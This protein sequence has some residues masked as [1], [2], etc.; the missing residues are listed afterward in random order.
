MSMYDLLGYNMSDYDTTTQDPRAQGG[1]EQGNQQ[2]S[3][4]EKLLEE[5]R[6]GREGA[7]AVG[8]TPG[9]AADMMGYAQAPDM[10]QYASLGGLQGL[11]QQAVP[12]Q[13]FQPTQGRRDPYLQSLLGV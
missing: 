5:S 11:L 2:M 4:W 8:D 13:Q 3:F 9:G 12:Q 1:A 6:R 7:K 10:S